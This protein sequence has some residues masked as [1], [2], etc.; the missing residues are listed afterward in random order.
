MYSF[1]FINSFV[2]FI[3]LFSSGPLSRGF[4]QQDLLRRLSWGILDT[5][6]NQRWDLTIRWR[7]GSTFSVLR[8]SQLRTFS[9]SVTPWTLCKDPMSAACIWED[10][11]FSHDPR[12]I[13]IGKDPNKNRFKNWQLSG[14][15]K[16]P[17]CDHRAIKLTKNCVSLTNPWINLL[18]LP[19]ATP[20]YNPRYLNFTSCSVLLL[21]CSFYCLAFR[22]RHNAS[23]FL[24]LIFIPARSYA[25]ENR[26]SAC[27]RPCSENA[28][29]T[30]LSEKSKRLILQLP[31]FDLLLDLVGT[32]Y[33]IQEDYEEG[34]DRT[35]PC[36]SP[37][38][39]VNGCDL[40]PPTRAQTSEQ[41]Y[42]DLTTSNRSSA[43]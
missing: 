21:T 9:R 29:S 23:V 34:G 17:F 7:N 31:N 1:I 16:L 14:V 40:T 3:Y 13:T 19:S 10:S 15:W 2:F 39:T 4:S 12:F 18:A 11:F 26:S 37:I 35:H 38:P 32:V 5:Y 25:A 41:E 28:S 43:L 6:L 24:V 8:I 33:P 30:K 42:S 22:E 20:K 27:W 36:R